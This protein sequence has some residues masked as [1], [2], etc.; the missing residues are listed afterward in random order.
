MHGEP[1]SFLARA[2]QGKAPDVGEPI[3]GSRLVQLVLSGGY[4][5]AVSR[6]SW[7][8]RQKWFSDY[9]KAIIERDVRDVAQ[10]IGFQRHCEQHAALILHVPPNRDRHGSGC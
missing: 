4:P 6:E 3:S 9:I 7:P 5:E 1:A 10:T 2:F 8:R